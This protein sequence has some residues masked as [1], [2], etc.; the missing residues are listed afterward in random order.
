MNATP[1]SS[2]GLRRKWLIIINLRRSQD[3]CRNFGC[4]SHLGTLSFL[5]WCHANSNVRQYCWNE[6]EWV[7]IMR[8][9]RQNFPTPFYIGPR[10][11]RGNASMRYSARLARHVRC[12]GKGVWYIHLLSAIWDVVKDWLLIISWIRWNF[13]V[14]SLAT[15]RLRLLLDMY[16][17]LRHL[18]GCS[19]N[20]P[21]A[22]E[23]LTT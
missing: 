14:R 1:K 13:E 18:R 2:K 6:T 15:K 19:G 22:I 4:H 11:G 17:H 9:R 12:T 23:G 8:N 5:F 10:E 20:L 21:P 7:E 3:R 16:W